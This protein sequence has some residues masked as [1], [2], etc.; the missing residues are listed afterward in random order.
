MER[1]SPK[2]HCPL[3]TSQLKIGKC[4]FAPAAIELLAQHQSTFLDVCDTMS[5]AR[6]TTHSV[7]EKTIV[8]VVS[9]IRQ[10][11]QRANPQWVNSQ[12]AFF[13]SIEQIGDTECA[14]GFRFGR[15]IYVT[16]WMNFSA[17]LQWN[18]PGTDLEE[19]SLNGRAEFIRRWHNAS[20]GGMMI[21]PRRR[22]LVKGKEAPY[23]ILIR[24]AKVDLET[25]W[26]EEGGL[27][28]WSEHL[29]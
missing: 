26:N 3:Q 12:L 29:I 21:M 27:R 24:L 1:C 10:T 17:D 25:L 8:A 4:T 28:E 11:I 2:G 23:E 9:E 14:L 20:D 19:D 22:T 5:Q 13:K 7:T 6:L 18:I 15:D 16:S